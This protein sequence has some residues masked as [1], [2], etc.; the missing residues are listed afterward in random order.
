MFDEKGI[1]RVGVDGGRGRGRR[2]FGRRGG[3]RR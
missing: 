2:G 3:R 1:V